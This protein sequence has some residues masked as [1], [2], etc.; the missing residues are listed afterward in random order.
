MKKFLAKGIVFVFVISLIFISIFQ[1]KQAN[2][3]SSKVTTLKVYMFGSNGTHY[4]NIDNVLK[5]FEKRTIKS[6]SLKMDLRFFPSSDYRTRLPM[7]LAAGE[8][9]D[10]C[11]DAPWMNL[12]RAASQ[13]L[14][15]DLEKYFNNPKYP[16]L[17]KAFS[18]DF[19]DANNK[20]FGK[21][22]AIPITQTFMDLEGFFYR[23][24]LAKKYGIEV[25]DYDS[26]YKFLQKVKENEKDITPLGAAG[27][28]FRNYKVDPVANK[29]GIFRITGSWGGGSKD[30][31]N[32]MVAI[33]K[34]GKKVLGVAALGDPTSA[35]A[36]FPAPYNK[37]EAFYYTFQMYRK[38][39]QFMD[40]DVMIR[41]NSTSD[42]LAGKIAAWEGTIGDGKWSLS[43]NTT[44]DAIR[45]LVP[46]AE[47]G[48][49]VGPDDYRNMVK[50]A[51]YT[52]YKAWNFV[53]IP[54]TSKK[55]EQTIKFL[56]WL[57]GS[58]DNIELLA[59]GI[60]NKDWIPVGKDEYKVPT[61]IDPA[62]T[63][64]FPVYELPWNPNY[65]RFPAGLPSNVKKLLQYEYSASA[66]SKIPFAGFTFD[67]TP[68]KTEI[69]KMAAIS[70]KYNKGL[71]CGIYA[72]VVGTIQKMNKELRSAGLDKVKT[73]IKKQMQK[74]LDSINK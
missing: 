32:M 20:F 21:L 43:S 7:M 4:Q 12:T 57:F 11:F 6:L 60:K 46:N 2:A 47:I 50:G 33:S 34:D 23:K 41:E 5:E 67:E 44:V 29:Y 51:I 26:F 59:Y 35:Y 31:V 64:F 14:Y 58:Q 1:V 37:P 71:R 56:D 53:C 13:D 10:L 45:K 22:V 52:D 9:I 8:E 63:Y 15:V 49:F 73:E 48:F 39:N 65:V 28:L 18:K 30:A 40:K 69:A 72:D 25:K 19:L 62:K 55:V 36:N 16:G 42:A 54:K 3:T 70:E 61:N 24:D 66:Y 68:V 74:Y 27:G 38:L 17:K